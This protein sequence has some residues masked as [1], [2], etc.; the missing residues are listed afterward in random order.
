MSLEV[1]YFDHAD[2]LEPGLILPLHVPANEDGEIL[3]HCNPKNAPKSLLLAVH[4]GIGEIQVNR[5]DEQSLQVIDASPGALSKSVSERAFTN[6]VEQ[7]A[8]RRSTLMPYATDAPT[9]WKYDGLRED[10]INTGT[11]QTFSDLICKHALIKQT[12]LRTT[13]LND[14]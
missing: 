12:R 9:F 14:L 5:E 8:Y 11:F 13:P 10:I 4:V 1:I 2:E 3:V 7:V 6:P